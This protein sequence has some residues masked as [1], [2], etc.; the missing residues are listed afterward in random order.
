MGKITLFKM[1]GSNLAQREISGSTD[2]QL[3]RKI[4]IWGKNGWVTES[5]HQKNQALES[6]LS[7]T[8]AILENKDLELQRAEAKAQELQALLDKLQGEAGKAKESA[9][10][11]KDITPTETE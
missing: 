4:E 2:K 1:I 3:N 10:K 9:K 6:K 7:L 8:E 5:K 11:A